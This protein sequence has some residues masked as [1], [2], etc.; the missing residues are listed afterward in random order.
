MA[1]T[2][3]WEHYSCLS[4]FRNFSWALPRNEDLIL[5]RAAYMHRVTAPNRYIWLTK[6]RWQRQRRWKI[7]WQWQISGHWVV[8][9]IL[10][11]TRQPYSGDPGER[12]WGRKWNRLTS[13]KRKWKWHFLQAG[14]SSLFRPCIW[15]T[16]TDGKAVNPRMTRMMMMDLLIT[17]MIMTRKVESIIM[18]IRIAS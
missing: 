4:K 10:S 12:K 9:L 15:F 14:S 7:Q 1:M 8:A 3:I 16:K 17:L 11:W 13:N 18:F 5:H 2:H 6:R